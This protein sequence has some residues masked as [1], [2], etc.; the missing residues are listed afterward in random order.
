MPESLVLA[1]ALILLFIPLVEL[2]RIL[3]HFAVLRP[4]L[5]ATGGVTATPMS[6]GHAL[7]LGLRLNR[8][9][10]GGARPVRGFRALV[11]LSPPGREAADALDAEVFWRAGFLRRQYLLSYALLTNQS[12]LD[13]V[14]R[15]LVETFKRRLGGS[16]YPAFLYGWLGRLIPLSVFGFLFW[17]FWITHDSSFSVAQQVLLGASLIGILLPNLRVLR[18]QIPE[19]RVMALLCDETLSADALRAG[20]TRLGF[21]IVAEADEA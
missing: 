16:L 2:T 4:R 1:L 7:K 13:A 8:Q 21:R 9:L 14:I 12:E 5:R 11:G 19:I 10:L 17:I 6:L 3:V 18:L 15:G 20:I